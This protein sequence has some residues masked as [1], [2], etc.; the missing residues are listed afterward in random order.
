ML[1]TL[2]G[3]ADGIPATRLVLTLGWAGLL[4]ALLSAVAPGLVARKRSTLDASLADARA[5]RV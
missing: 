2:L 4:P 1:R 3:A 5:R